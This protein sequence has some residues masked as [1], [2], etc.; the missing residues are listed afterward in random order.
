MTEKQFEAGA[1]IYHEGDVPDCAYQVVS[2][3]VELFETSKGSETQIKVHNAGET[4]GENALFDPWALRPFTARA[5]TNTVLGTM[6]V[7]EFKS[8]LNQCPKPLMPYLMQSFAKMKSAKVKEK[9]TSIAV[10]GDITKVIINPNSDNMRAQLRTLDIP[11]NRLPFRIGGYPEGGEINRRDQLHLYIAAQPNPLRVSRQHCEI[12]IENKNILINDL[13][14][15]FNTTVNGITIGRG[16][17]L[18]SNPLKK[19][20]NEVILGAKDG[21][22]KLSLKCE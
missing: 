17:G 9:P 15:R 14:S 11:L 2:G 7:E 22:Y 3:E 10:L 21:P 5:T 12:I 16:R 19:G 8:M 20:M 18:Y 1:I 13:G 4:F 6:S